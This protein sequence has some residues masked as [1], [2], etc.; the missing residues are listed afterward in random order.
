[1]R[2]AILAFMAGACW[3]QAQ[4]DLPTPGIAAAAVLAAL[5]LC[6]IRHRLAI[7]PAGVVVG[8]AWA[9]LAAGI[10]LS[11]SLPRPLEG[12]D[13]LITGTIDSLPHEFDGGARFNFRV[14]QV[15][16]PHA[17]VPRR[18]AISWYGPP[19][20]RDLSSPVEP[21]ERWRL[22]VRLQRPHGNANPYGFD[23]EAW[24]LE[25]GVRATGYVRPAGPRNARLDSFVPRF[26]HVVER[27]RATL[28][29]HI[30]RQL[31][32]K[33]YAGVI[34]ALVI[35]DQRGIP[36]SDWDVFNRTGIGHLVSIS[37]LHITMVAGLA[38]WAMSSLWRRS[39]FVEGA[40]L[41]LRL[42]AQ[43]A[44]ALAGAVVALLYVL[45][46]GFGVPAQRTFY[47]LA[48]V[49][50]AL[51]CGRTV[52][53]SQVLCLALG[54]VVVLDPWAVLGAGFWLSFGAVA[55]IL[56]ANLGRV[57]AD[58][59][60]R[61]TFGLAAQTQYAVT[62]GLV[63]LTML[64]FSQVSLASPLANAVA[65]PLVSLLVTPLA[66]LGA[67]LPAPLAGWILGLA[68]LG[69]ELLA[70]GLQVLA[71]SPLAVV[72]AAAPQPWVFALALLGTAWMLAP[73]GWPHRWA[74]LVAWTPML[75]QM[76][77]A[78]PQGSFT[79][80][81]F[82]VG[83]GMALLVETAGHRLLYDTGPAYA[84]GADAAGRVLLPYLRGRGIGR[85]D[86]LVVSH[87]DVDHSGGALTLLAG[88]KVDSVASSL[89]PG[90]P[91]VRAARRHTRCMAGQTWTWDGVRFEMLG[92]AAASYE[93]PGLKA[94]AR[95][96]VLRVSSAGRAMLLAADIEAAQEAQLLAHGPGQL[97]ADVL[98]A[99]HH[100]SGTSS[101][102]AFLTAV[103]PSVGIFQVGYRNRY[104]H[105]K[106]EVYE[107]YGSHG[108]RRL[109]TD[110]SGAVTLQFGATV[111]VTEYRSE[112]RRYWHGR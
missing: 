25:Q 27:S 14:E 49:A 104:R 31:E 74:G 108:I 66:L 20:P 8:A 76:P 64:L 42:P 26:G 57:R 22:V 2:C 100:G 16:T 69:I 52:A 83:Q 71:A 63:P 18:I 4:P 13:I 45:L 61:R 32:G 12:T 98:L 92:P 89:A 11:D 99:P 7:L 58:Q 60:W 107:R 90:H 112:R 48:A 17:T 70:E 30:L 29:R 55:V 38:A 19:T 62:I 105:P 50:A 24:L 80:T 67:L 91:V 79:V 46:A 37:G 75:T 94:N 65:I 34:V 6:A 15:L 44:A 5:A 88:V 106:L 54:V 93:D 35:G 56:Y 21:G 47:M 68:H 23:Y 53:L 81:A 87:S 101:T 72:N 102:A 33:R 110:A 41:P 111:D 28:R 40:A 51:W 96:C 109:R 84:P 95:S 78:P 1:M 39:F 59:G 86:A 82:D 85:L 73:R 3:L 10:A 9:N 103:K 77:T 97:R 36:Q 43:K